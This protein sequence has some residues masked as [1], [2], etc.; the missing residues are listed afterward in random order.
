MVIPLVVGSLTLAGCIS[1]QEV[2]VPTL[3]RE[4]TSQDAL[5]DGVFTDAESFA[6]G[7]D[8]STS[9][10]V[11]EIDGVRVFLA[12]SLKPQDVCV[13][14]VETTSTAGAA[15]GR[16]IGVQGANG[17]V[18]V[19]LTSDGII[20]QDDESGGDASVGEWVVLNEDVLARTID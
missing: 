19:R 4:R 5:P 18:E 11:G 7:P 2:R 1:S 9:R 12:R 20:P 13:V 6:S 15:C 3:E 10:F 14:F 16:P 17:H 8:T